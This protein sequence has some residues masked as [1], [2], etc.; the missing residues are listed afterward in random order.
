MHIRTFAPVI[1]KN[2]LTSPGAFNPHQAVK[3][4]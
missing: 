2:M 4:V 1:N 3:Q